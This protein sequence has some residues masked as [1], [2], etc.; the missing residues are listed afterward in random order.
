MLSDREGWAVGR[1]GTLLHYTGA[2]DLST[3]YKGVEPRHAAAGSELTFTLKVQNSGEA[4]A[5]SVTVTDTID[6]ALLTYVPGSLET[7]MGTIT[8]PTN[9]FVVDVG[10]LK[11]GEV[12]TITLRAT[13]V[14]Q[15]LDCWFAPNQAV[16]AYEGIQLTRRGTATIGTCQAVYLPLIM[17]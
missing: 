5:L 1:F 9:P 2:P 17:R 4:R 12:A 6:P 7:T 15:G 14:D 16:I 3:S 10:D 8:N 13:V 11:V